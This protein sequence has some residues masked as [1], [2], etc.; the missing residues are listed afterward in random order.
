M[1]KIYGIK[2]CSSVKKGLDFLENKGFEYEFLDI[3]KLDDFIKD[4]DKD[5]FAIIS[6]GGY[7][8]TRLVVELFNKYA[9]EEGEFEAFL[10]NESA[11]QCL[12]FA[13]KG[14]VAMF[15]FGK[16]GINEWIVIFISTLMW[17]LNVV[18]PVVIGSYYVMRFKLNDRKA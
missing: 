3:K 15:F 8:K 13:V 12:D 11:F 1:I 5:V 14:S 17:F 9:T 16:Y 7:G 6:D 4:S 10:L 2:N 18:L